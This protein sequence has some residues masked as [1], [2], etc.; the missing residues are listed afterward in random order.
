MDDVDEDK[1]FADFKKAKN[2]SSKFISD[3]EEDPEKCKRNQMKSSK[4]KI[5]PIDFAEN[6][7]VD[8]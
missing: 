3:G 2:K 5:T 1:A 4:I 7:K 8:D 6:E